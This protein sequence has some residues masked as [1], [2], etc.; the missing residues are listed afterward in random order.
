MN[1]L[2]SYPDAPAR[3]LWNF[4]TYLKASNGSTVDGFNSL[5][6][7]EY[8]E[9]AQQL[10]AASLDALNSAYNLADRP[11]EQIAGKFV[12]RIDELVCNLSLQSELIG[13]LRY[14]LGKARDALV[15]GE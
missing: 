14:D 6:V 3:I 2:L 10:V 13:D 11:N 1:T 9:A 5:R 12:A 15:N 4:N 7:L 8:L